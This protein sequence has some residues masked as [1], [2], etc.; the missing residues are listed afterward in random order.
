MDEVIGIQAARA[1]LRE[2]AQR[3]RCL[4]IQ[5]GRRDARNQARA[6][7]GRHPQPGQG[8]GPGCVSRRRNQSV[9]WGCVWQRRRPDVDAMSDEIRAR[10]LLR[11]DPPTPLV[12]LGRGE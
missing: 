9:L 5:R 6:R 1:L 11:F 10:A 7:P 3:G 8:R 2:N 12:R 4:Y